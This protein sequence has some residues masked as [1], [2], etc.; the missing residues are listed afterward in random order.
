MGIVNALPNAAFTYSVVSGHPTNAPLSV[1]FNDQSTGGPFV[2]WTWN[3]GD[4]SNGAE[5]FQQ[6]PI[7]IFQ[8]A[9][10]FQVTL[11][12]WNV[13]NSSVSAPQSILVTPLPQFNAVPQTGPAPLQV[14]FT[15]TSTGQPQEWNWSFGDGTFSNGTSPSVSHT[16]PIANTYLT[17]VSVTGNGVSNLSQNT[18]ITVNPQPTIVGIT[19]SSVSDQKVNTTFSFTG[20]ST[21]SPLSWNW[22]FGDGDSNITSQNATYNYYSNNHNVVANIYLVNLTSTGRGGTSGTAQVALAVRPNASF[23][24]N[25]KTISTDTSLSFTSTSFGVDSQATYDWDFGDGSPHGSGSISPAHLYKPGSYT[26]TLTVKE[27]GLQD[28]ATGTVNSDSGNLYPLMSTINGNTF[29]RASKYGVRPGQPVNLIAYSTRSIIN[30][31][32]TINATGIGTTYYW[33]VYGN[34]DPTDHYYTFGPSPVAAAVFNLYPAEP[35]IYNV[36]LTV[37]DSTLTPY[38]VTMPRMIV[39]REG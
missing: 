28:V 30:P 27:N 8:S 13:T 36:R 3:F 18:V 14:Q 4:A 37:D 5:R 19:P 2:N 16:Y 6:N 21:G 34:Q 31:L 26:V 39:V 32:W 25:Y 10:N 9:G 35:D 17:N 33:E 12:V 29:F 23:T 15:D 24:P 22:S 38:T 7:H 1:Q 11:T 20:N